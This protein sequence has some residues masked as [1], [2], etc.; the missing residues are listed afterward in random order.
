[1]PPILHI[2]VLAKFLD[3]DGFVKV[4]E[5]LKCKGQGAVYAIGGVPDA[6]L[7]LGVSKNIASIL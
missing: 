6:E 1:L 5:Y 2:Y 3:I 4:D 7:S